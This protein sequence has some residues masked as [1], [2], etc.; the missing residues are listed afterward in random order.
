MIYDPCISTTRWAIC[1]LPM[2]HICAFAAVCLILTKNGGNVVEEC[3]K[4]GSDNAKQEQQLGLP[5]RQ[6]AVRTLARDTKK[7]QGGIRR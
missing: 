5:A 4:D 1:P 6:D 2:R 3:R 7:R